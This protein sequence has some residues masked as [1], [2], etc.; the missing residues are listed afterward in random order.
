MM[1]YLHGIPGLPIE[2]DLLPK[3]AIL[4]KQSSL[5]VSLSTSEAALWLDGGDEAAFRFG[6]IH[7]RRERCER[8]HNGLNKHFLQKT[9]PPPVDCFI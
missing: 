6:M 2:E 3:V 8:I 9:W 7:H 5:A 1:K 4:T